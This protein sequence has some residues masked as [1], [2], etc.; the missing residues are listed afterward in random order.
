MKKHIAELVKVQGVLLDG[1]F[2]RSVSCHLCCYVIKK[3]SALNCSACSTL[4]RS[5]LPHTWAHS[6]DPAQGIHQVT[7]QQTVAVASLPRVG[8]RLGGGVC[9]AKGFDVGGVISESAGLGE[10]DQGL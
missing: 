7:H 4:S 9:R 6:D 1:S 10:E 5:V 2:W 8:R 3:K